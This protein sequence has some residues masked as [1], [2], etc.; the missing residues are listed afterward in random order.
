LNKFG[1][2]VQS[3][4]PFNRDIDRVTWIEI[5][6]DSDLSLQAK[7]PAYHQVAT[8]RCPLAGCTLSKHGKCT[9]FGFKHCSRLKKHQKAD[10]SKLRSAL[11]Y[12]RLGIK[13]K[14]V[15]RK[16]FIDQLWKENTLSISMN[17]CSRGAGIHQILTIRAGIHQILTIRRL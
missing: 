2:E 6:S 13:L 7:L 12:T 9:C 5:L 16:Y 15:E 4:D 1:F 11:C 14:A 17:T 10:A 8:P 3:D